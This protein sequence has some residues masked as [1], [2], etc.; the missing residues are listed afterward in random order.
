[1]LLSLINVPVQIAIGNAL[2]SIINDLNA[3]SD[4]S[5]GEEF[6]WIGTAYTL[7]STAFLPLSSCVAEVS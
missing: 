7:S 4:S 6:A 2:P 5:Q 3:G 1:M